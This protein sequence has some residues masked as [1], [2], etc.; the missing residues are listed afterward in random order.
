MDIVEARDR[1]HVTVPEEAVRQQQ[2]IPVRHAE[3]EDI[4]R[5]R[6]VMDA[7]KRKR[8][9]TR[10]GERSS[11]MKEWDYNEVLAAVAKAMGVE[12][13]ENDL[14]KEDVEEEENEMVCLGVKSCTVYSGGQK[15][16]NNPATK[17][18]SNGPIGKI[19]IDFDHNY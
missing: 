17:I 10:T 16:P 8:T 12:L 5:A 7:V 1:F 14:E 3:E 15:L 19:N 9:T 6:H 2:M 11:T 18:Y 4:I 13:D